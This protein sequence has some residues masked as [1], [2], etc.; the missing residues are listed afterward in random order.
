M[1]RLKRLP[2]LVLIIAVFAFAGL[3]F[4]KDMIT[5]D[6]PFLGE[7]KRL[8]AD[9]E[10]VP[11]SN[12]SVIYYGKDIMIEGENS[13]IRA[14]NMEGTILWSMKLHGDVTSIKSCGEGFVVNIGNKSITTISKTGEVLWQYEMV[15][16]AS[17]IYS[18]EEGLL[19]IQYRENGYNSFEIFNIKGVKYCQGAINNAQV[20]SF[21]GTADK[22]Y[23]ISMID[24]SSGKI[25]TRLATYNNK[26]EIIWAQDF[27]D[28]IIP[29]LIYNSRGELIAVSDESMMKYR[30]DGKL[31]KK[32]DFQ[33]PLIKVSLS[34][35]LMVIIQKNREFY[36]VFVYD[37]DLRQI[38]SAAV[39]SKPEGV[40]AGHK[41]FLV[42]DKDN[43]TMF[44]RQGNIIALYESN[45]DI[46]SAYI[47]DDT[48]I[49]IVSNRRLQKL[50]Y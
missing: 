36:D 1:T 24:I 16:P 29:S 31:V 11:V 7:V 40:F 48:S 19:L 20:V 6:K 12:N 46:N 22:N 41:H 10:L 50:G 37:L 47:Y 9:G 34:D 13:N 44:S 43:L 23:T 28:I 32:E 33:N 38:G 18:S 8:E 35:D 45:I 5:G 15:I 14:K 49:Y 42:Y 26:G 21:D 39:K 27:E 25:I 4:L 30:A 17:D 2:Y 3:L